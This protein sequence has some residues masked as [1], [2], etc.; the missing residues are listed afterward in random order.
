MI[1]TNTNSSFIY[2]ISAKRST[3][4]KLCHRIDQGERVQF[5]DGDVHTATNILK[6]FLRELDQPLITSNVDEVVHF[7]GEII[8]VY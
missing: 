1:T 7:Y 4:R 3:V 8:I 2:R 6:T 5:T